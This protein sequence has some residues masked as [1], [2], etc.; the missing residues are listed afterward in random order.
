[1][2]CQNCGTELPEG[3]R[4]CPQCGLPQCED[5]GAPPSAGPEVR[6][7]P[8]AGFRR[9]MRVLLSLV[10][11]TAILV[12]VLAVKKGGLHPA[13]APEPAITAAEP[14]DPNAP[15]I[16]AQPQ[17]VTADVGETVQFSVE[18]E[19]EDLTYQWQYLTFGTREWSD[20]GMDDALTPTVSVEATPERNGRR[21]RCIVTNRSGAVITEAA[22]LDVRAA[23]VITIQPEDAAAPEGDAVTFRFEARGGDMTCLW[24]WRPPDSH[25]WIDV[26]QPGEATWELTVTATAESSG[27]Q[28]RCIVENQYG[29]AVTDAATLTV[30]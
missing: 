25:D 8:P 23:P 27:R 12:V 29:S 22:V 11:V 9:L 1:M 30:E 3:A 19:G 15:V 17:D 5:G 24:Q 20:S 10:C 6:N 28:Y 26:V 16:R 21:Y 2:R 18:A 14:A 4:F 7:G 13:A